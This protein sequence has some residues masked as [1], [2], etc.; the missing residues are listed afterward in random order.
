MATRSL[1]LDDLT[2]VWETLIGNWNALGSARNQCWN[3]RLA[4]GRSSDMSQWMYQDHIS[5]TATLNWN[6]NNNNNTMQQNDTLTVDDKLIE[7]A[8]AKQPWQRWNHSLGYF[9]K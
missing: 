9:T 5:H 7:D 8:E 6:A 2:T 1:C 3:R 4:L